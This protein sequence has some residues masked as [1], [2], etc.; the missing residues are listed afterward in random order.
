[1][2]TVGASR[3]TTTP[4]TKALLRALAVASA[5]GPEVSG[6]HLADFAGP[7]GLPMAWAVRVL[8]A[9]EREALARQRTKGADLTVAQVMLRVAHPGPK[10]DLS[11]VNDALIVE[12]GA[13]DALYTR[14][15]GS[16]SPLTALW[17]QA[18][19]IEFEEWRWATGGA[20]PTPSADGRWL[21]MHWRLRNPSPETAV[22]L[23]RR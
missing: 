21:V 1:M 13:I 19:V 15:R 2:A 4:G 3:D 22:Y 17:G 7:D 16:A 8:D 6:M 12:S 10:A 20:F 11:M 23:P 9:A 18:L 14:T 5:G